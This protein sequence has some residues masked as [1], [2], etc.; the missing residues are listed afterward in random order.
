LNA[1]DA[2]SVEA[3]VSLDLRI[4]RPVPLYIKLLF[5]RQKPKITGTPRRLFAK[6]S[7]IDN[8]RILTS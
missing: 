2:A 1:L 3:D 8:F 5:Q 6:K 4:K 7:A